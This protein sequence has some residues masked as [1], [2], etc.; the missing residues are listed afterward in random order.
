VGCHGG[1]G[2]GYGGY[3]CSCSGSCGGYGCDGY[4][5]CMGCHGGYGGTGSYGCY[6]CGGYGAYGGY[7]PAYGAPVAPAAP[8]PAETVPAPKKT[9]SPTSARLIVDVPADATL[10][11]DGNAVKTTTAARRT[12]NTPPLAPGQAYYYMLRAEVTRDG[13]TRTETQRVIVRPGEVATA[14]FSGLESNATATAQ[15]SR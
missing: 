10:Y 5:G 11:V 12:F 1:Y 15:A 4:W 7:A 9:T 14:R 13:Q 2:S 6:G 3:G 8:A